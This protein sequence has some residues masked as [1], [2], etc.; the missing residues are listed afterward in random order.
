MGCVDISEL[1]LYVLPEVAIPEGVPRFKFEDYIVLKEIGVEAQVDRRINVMKDVVIQSDE[2]EDK[3][4]QRQIQHDMLL[5]LSTIPTLCCLD[6]GIVKDKYITLCYV[7]TVPS[8]MKFIAPENFHLEN[9][10][11]DLQ[12][13]L[14][15]K[16]DA[17]SLGLCLLQLY[18]NGRYPLEDIQM[19][20]NAAIHCYLL[21]RRFSGETV[22]DDHWPPKPPS[23]ASPLFRD[24][25]SSCLDLDVS[26]RASVDQ[27]L[28]HDFLVSNGSISRDATPLL[29]ATACR[30]LGRESGLTFSTQFFF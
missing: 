21:S 16:S 2:L 22:V 5:E 6:V 10:L 27:L 23:H 14:Y 19:D 8:Y 13:D 20:T 25:I 15:R 4:H 24:F 28:T 9:H 11:V 29:G 12:S 3:R 7:S 1:R 26:R 17:W 30:S 18:N